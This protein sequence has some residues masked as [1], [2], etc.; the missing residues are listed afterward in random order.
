MLQ[1]RARQTTSCRCRVCYLF[2]GFNLCKSGIPM[3]N[4]ILLFIYKNTKCLLYL[5]DIWDVI[6]ISLKGTRE[7]LLSISWHTNSLQSSLRRSGKSHGRLPDCGVHAKWSKCKHQSLRTDHI[8]DI[9]VNFLFNCL[10]CY[11][12]AKALRTDALLIQFSKEVCRKCY[13]QY[14]S[15]CVIYRLQRYLDSFH[16]W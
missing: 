15:L 14:K 5:N 8:H 13:M 9:Q 12:F 4:C 11:F 6:H 1:K 2:S 7:G 3:L 10:V 16:A